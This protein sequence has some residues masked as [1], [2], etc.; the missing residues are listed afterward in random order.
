MWLIGTI[1]Y[2]IISKTPKIKYI[3]ISFCCIIFLSAIGPWSSIDISR[4]NQ[5]NRLKEYFV[6]NEI[7][8][9]GKFK[10][11]K[12]K[13]RK[14]IKD[15]SE[16]RS[17]INYLDQTHGINDFQSLSTE[18]S[19]KIA[20]ITILKKFN[21]KN[22]KANPIS[23]QLR[24]KSNPEKVINIKNY[25]FYTESMY[26]YEGKGN[27][28]YTYNKAGIKIHLVPVKHSIN[29]QIIQHDNLL[30]EFNLNQEFQKLFEKNYESYSYKIPIKKMTFIIENKK[31]KLKLEI[32]Y[33]RGTYMK[34][35]IVSINNISGNIFLKLK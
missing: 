9:K 13:K 7:L 33:L 14:S 11:N 28:K 32:E 29:L 15:Y 18:K 31:I 24:S 8:V 6:K 1:L 16:I 10:I 35:K 5:L 19:N 4:I 34:K 2:F 20:A 30:G 3:V 26:F 23:F 27:L 22:P 17:I 12:L 21:I 25:D